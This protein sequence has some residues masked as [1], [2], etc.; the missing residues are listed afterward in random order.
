M[1]IF[2]IFKSFIIALKMILREVSLAKDVGHKP[3][4]LD[5]QVMTFRTKGPLEE[6]GTG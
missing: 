6:L 3:V 1:L 2:F 4:V 5:Y